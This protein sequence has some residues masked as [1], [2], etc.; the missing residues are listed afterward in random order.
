MPSTLESGAAPVPR[1]PEDLD[2][3]RRAL[4]IM[5][6]VTLRPE[7]ARAIIKAGHKERKDQLLRTHGRRGLEIAGEEL[8]MLRQAGGTRAELEQYPHFLQE[9]VDDL[10]DGAAERR[11][12]ELDEMA[13]DVAEDAV[14]GPA[15]LRQETPAEKCERARLCRRQAAASLALAR[16]LEQEARHESLGLDRRTA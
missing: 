14:Q 9:L 15:L 16:A 3:T 5:R 12:C 2:L 13:S 8:L 1:Y 7:V 6:D 10:F 11:A 4:A